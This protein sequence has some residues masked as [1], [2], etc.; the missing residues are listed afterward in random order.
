MKET[1]K[2]WKEVKKGI[3][4]L[5]MDNYIFRYEEEWPKNN[6]SLLNSPSFSTIWTSVTSFHII[7]TNPHRSSFIIKKRK[8]N[9]WQKWIKSFVVKLSH[10]N[11][12]EVIIISIF[13][14]RQLKLR[15]KLQCCFNWFQ[16]F[17]TSDMFMVIWKLYTISDCWHCEM[18]FSQKSVS[19]C[20]WCTSSF[21]TV[22]SIDL[23]WKWNSILTVIV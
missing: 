23:N 8:R 14:S 18:K 20:C 4:V 1:A 10:I 16:I 5:S 12:Q 3:C 2:I 9:I 15:V 17:L 22:A 7:I 21:S 19:F 13:T 6:I 11:S